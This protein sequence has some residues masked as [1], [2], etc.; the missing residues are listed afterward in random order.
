MVKKSST[1]STVTKIKST[2]IEF[3]SLMNKKFMKECGVD[4]LLHRNDIRRLYKLAGGKAPSH[5]GSLEYWFV[6]KKEIA[7]LLEVAKEDSFVLPK[8]KVKAKIKK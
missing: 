1:K 6:G 4:Y 8:K 2:N 5:L 3:L 7:S